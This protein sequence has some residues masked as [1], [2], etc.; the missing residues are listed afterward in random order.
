MKISQILL[1]PNKGE[2]DKVVGIITAVK[3][4]ATP[5]AN[6]IPHGIHTQDIVIQDEDGQSLTAQIM[7]KDMHLPPKAR[8]CKILITASD[9]GT[10]LS[11]NI[12]KQNVTLSVSKWAGIQV[13]ENDLD[14]SGPTQFDKPSAQRAKSDTPSNNAKSNNAPTM[15]IEILTD[16][17]MEIFNNVLGRLPEL[18][19]EVAVENARCI[20]TTLFIEGNRQGLIRPP[21]QEVAKQAEKPESQEQRNVEPQRPKTDPKEVLSK[22]VHSVRSETLD[23]DRASAAMERNSLTW[24]QV[25]DAA[26]AHL[27]TLY[28]QETV[29]SIYDRMKASMMASGVGTMDNERFCREICQGFSTFAE[30]VKAFNKSEIDPD[31]IPY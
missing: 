29:D 15:T 5:T 2:V 21:R 14:Q 27:S 4:P 1:L 23:V 20:T 6:Q 16:S 30:E 18:S 11:V 10:G 13:F 22:I 25:Y 8:G 26:S 31:D 12:Y 3:A 24:E 28:G 19:P 7:S 9:R 17:F